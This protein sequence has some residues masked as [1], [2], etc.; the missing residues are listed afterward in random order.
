MPK[1][2]S[3]KRD[4][5]KTIRMDKKQFAIMMF[6]TPTFAAIVS[7]VLVL[8]VFMPLQIPKVNDSSIEVPVLGGEVEKTEPTVV[9]GTP[10]ETVVTTEIPATNTQIEEKTA[11][12]GTKT[13]TQKTTK[14]TSNTSTKSNSSA[15]KTSSTKTNTTTKNTSTTSNTSNNTSKKEV[16]KSDKE[17][18]EE[19]LETAKTRIAVTLLDE[20]DIEVYS[21]WYEKPI[22]SYYK[23][24]VREGAHKSWENGTCGHTK[25]YDYT[26]HAI[27][28][29]NELSTYGV[30]AKTYTI[31]Q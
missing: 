25:E 7:V 13:T 11:T 17:I 12:D 16:K 14:T 18:C 8:S 31:W 29:E 21:N 3:N 22:V 24:T 27:L 4:Q 1:N 19:T 6:L 15:S 2:H 28:E 23:Y 30:E 10:V 20:A 5:R 26:E 9:D